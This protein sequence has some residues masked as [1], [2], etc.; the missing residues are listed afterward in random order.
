MAKSVTI[1][2]RRFGKTNW[3]VSAI[4]LGC[5]SFGDVYGTMTPSEQLSLMK[6]ALDSGINILDT[7]PYYGQTTSETNVGRCL[8]DLREIHPRNA[9]YLCTKMGRYTATK[10][11]FSGKMVEKS[12]A[13]SME[14][15]QTDYLDLVS[16]HDFEFVGFYPDENKGS[17]EQ[18]WKETLPALEE[19]KEKGTISH[20]GLGARPLIVMDYVSR[21]YGYDKI[22]S[23]LNY[24]NW[25][26]TNE[27]L[28]NYAPRLRKYDIGFMQGGVT[29]MGLLTPQGPQEWNNAPEELKVVCKE[30]V[31]M[32]H[33][34]TK[35]SD[36][37]KRESILRLG[38]L[39]GMANDDISTILV[40]PTSVE[41]LANN[42][43]WVT[44]GNGKLTEED[45]ALIKE[46]QEGVFAN[47]MHLGWVE[48][49]T[50]RNICQS[51]FE[52]SRWE[53]QLDCK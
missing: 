5:A 26:I 6:Y 42:I 17:L 1:P 19:Q 11:D 43:K 38:F 14:R 44:E 31:R 47:T 18:I 22:S 20:Y 21:M 34:R 15:L 51:L 29:M 25:N 39:H 35:G 45:W 36:R 9:Y 52:S 3:N 2:L 23:F 30:A 24:N 10:F 40:G 13:E 27:T 33:D 48:D 37:E 4:G 49:G 16:I 41:Q 12:I 8:R 28:R 46:L 50:Q 7:S 53:E 32:V